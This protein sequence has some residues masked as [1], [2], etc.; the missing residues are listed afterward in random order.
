MAYTRLI[1][2]LV[3][4]MALTG[5][6]SSLIPPKTNTMRPEAQKRL[7]EIAQQ[8]MQRGGTEAIR[9]RANLQNLCDIPYDQFLLP[10]VSPDSRYVAT[11]T[12]LSPEAPTRLAEPGAPSPLGTGIEVWR[13][14]QAT[15]DCTMAYRLSPPL[16]LG[17]SADAKGFLV[18]APLPDGVRDIGKVDWVSGEIE[19]LVKNGDVNAFGCIG[20]NGEL[21]W[22][23]RPV[24]EPGFTLVIRGAS[25]REFDIDNQGGNWYFPS[26]SNQN[27]R[28]YAFWVSSTGMMKL[29]TM[30]TVSTETMLSS[31][32]DINIMPKGTARMAS[33]AVAAHPVI[34][35]V[36]ANEYENFIF[37][38]PG[39]RR[40]VVW[41]PDES[42]DALPFVLL[43]QAVAAVGDVGG[44]YL[45]STPTELR[46]V[47]PSRLHR[48]VRLHDQ[49]AIPR[50]TNDANWRFI[51]MTPNGGDAITLRALIPMAQAPTYTPD[52]PPAS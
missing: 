25:G 9:F 38:H 4:I 32:R 14:N 35:D 49:V 39:E 52:Q 33:Q 46:Y 22:C 18:E 16:L 48:S 42:E 1:L 28:L 34:H 15:G 17:R 37:Y 10:I 2:S 8:E 27:D 3:A 6:V 31:L 12:G 5:C 29:A 30:K 20:P 50:A 44:R 47:D 7:Y 21:S 19:W 51:L 26:W 23:S 36:S 43:D 45:V 13:L 41:N 11:S 24:N 40:V